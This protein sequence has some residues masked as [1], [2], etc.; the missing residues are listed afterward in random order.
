[1]HSNSNDVHSL[2]DM[3]RG[4]WA[5]GTVE[6]EQ[7]AFRAIRMLQHVHQVHVCTSRFMVIVFHVLVLQ[8]L[9]FVALSVA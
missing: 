8:L 4:L 2:L 6:K 5:T 1:M 9:R 7:N 3:L